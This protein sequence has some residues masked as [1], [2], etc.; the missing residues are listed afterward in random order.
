MLNFIHVSFCFLLFL[1][2]GLGLWIGL[3][4]GIVNLKNILKIFHRWRCRHSGHSRPPDA[5]VRTYH[6]HNPNPTVTLNPNP[7]VT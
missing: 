7:N 3:G 6:K 5:C 1:G 2:L 4:F